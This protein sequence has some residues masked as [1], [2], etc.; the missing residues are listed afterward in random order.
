M[1]RVVT[2]FTWVLDGVRGMTLAVWVF[3][4]TLNWLLL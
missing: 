4:L 2:L 3:V 1:V